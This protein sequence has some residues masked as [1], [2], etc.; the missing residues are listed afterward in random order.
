MDGDGSRGIQF[1]VFD[2]GRHRSSY[3]DADENRSV[4]AR[5]HC[6]LVPPPDEAS[7]R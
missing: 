7:E 1:G 4:V 3:G 2:F 5:E 6:R